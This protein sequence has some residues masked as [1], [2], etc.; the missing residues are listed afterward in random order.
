MLVA[1]WETLSLAPARTVTRPQ[2]DTSA[3]SG[4]VLAFF[5]WNN[6]DCVGS[7]FHASVL[8][9]REKEVIRQLDAGVDVDAIFRYETVWQGRQQQCTGKAIHLA[10]SRCHLSMVQLLLERNASLHSMVTRD[11]QDN[12]EV[13]HA[14]VFREGRGGCREMI[15]FLCARGADIECLNAN[16]WSCQ[17]VA[18]QTGNMETIWAVERARAKKLGLDE[19]SEDA[20]QEVEGPFNC[21]NERG[22]SLY[23]AVDGGRSG[24]EE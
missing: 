19:S 2:L 18:F 11:G 10:A 21:L 7:S 3:S 1:L 13:I 22:V 9:N 23:L 24:I 16:N 14:A 15:D 20:E 8:N 12:Y 6:R 17:H 4:G 5:K